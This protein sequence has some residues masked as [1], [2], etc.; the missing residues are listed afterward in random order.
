MQLELIQGG[1]A[2]STSGN[3][4]VHRAPLLMEQILLTS[5]KWPS[6]PLSDGASHAVHGRT[7]LRPSPR[8]LFCRETAT[9]NAAQAC[10][11]EH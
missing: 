10:K 4:K 8:R 2:D 11:E 7:F 5:I 6:G 1:M 3:A 9:Q